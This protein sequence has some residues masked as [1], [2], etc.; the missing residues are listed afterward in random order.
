M[1]QRSRGTNSS[2]SLSAELRVVVQGPGG[3]V[4][5]EERGVEPRGLEAVEERLAR[6][7][8]GDRVV[9]LREGDG[10]GHDP[11]PLAAEVGQ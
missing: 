8:P 3:E 11:D 6:L 7:E 2:T 9:L 5:V 10:A 1:F 4:G